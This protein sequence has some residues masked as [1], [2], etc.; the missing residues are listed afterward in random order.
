MG[1]TSRDCSAPANVYESNYSSWLFKVVIY[2]FDVAVFTVKPVEV[3]IYSSP[4]MNK[5][6]STVR[7]EKKKLLLFFFFILYSVPLGFL[8]VRKLSLVKHCLYTWCFT[9]DVMCLIMSV[10]W[11]RPVFGI[12]RALPSIRYS[13]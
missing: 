2:Y 3:F 13:Q 7:F 11:V 9:Q 10:T 6:S 12:Y 4:F 1:I 5:M 8:N